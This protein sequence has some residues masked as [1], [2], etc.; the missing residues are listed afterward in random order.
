MRKLL[1]FCINALGLMLTLVLAL[2]AICIP[3]RNDEG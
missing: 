1:D 3:D 2:V